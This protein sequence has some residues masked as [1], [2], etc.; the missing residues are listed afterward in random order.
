MVTILPL[1]DIGGRQLLKAETSG[2][3]KDTALTPR[4]IETARNLWLV[5]LGITIACILSLKAVGMSWLDVI[6]HAF[7]AMGLGGFSKHDASVG[8][9]NSPAIEFVLIV[10]MLLA[11]W[12]LSPCFLRSLPASTMLDLGWAWWGQQ[13]RCA[14]RF[15]DLGGHDCHAGWAVGNYYG[16]DSVYPVFLEMVKTP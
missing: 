2:S 6:C 14:N 16:V 13:L 8:Y 12:I 7:A 10:F 15:S 11:G 4:I 5:Y 1:L 9:F 3:M